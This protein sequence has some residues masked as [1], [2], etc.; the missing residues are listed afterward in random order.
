MKFN[1]PF[2]A[3]DDS[4]SETTEI[5]LQ[6]MSSSEMDEIISV[7]PSGEIIAKGLGDLEDV[8]ITTPSNGQIIKYNSTSRKWENGSGGNAAASDSSYDNTDSGLEAD[9]LQDEFH[10]QFSQYYV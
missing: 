4:A 8:T 10:G 5:G 3:T 1:A 2:T 9:N 7:L 6:K